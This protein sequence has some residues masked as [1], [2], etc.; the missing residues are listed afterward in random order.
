MDLF[1]GDVIVARVMSHPKV[2]IEGVIVE[3]PY[4]VE[5]YTAATTGSHGRS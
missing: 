5:P 3:N 1:G 2:W 4:L